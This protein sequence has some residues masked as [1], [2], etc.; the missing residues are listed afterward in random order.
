MVYVGPLHF[1]NRRDGNNTNRQKHSIAS[2]S[3]RGEMGRLPAGRVGHLGDHLVDFK[4]ERRHR[5]A[6]RGAAGT[7]TPGL[8]T[9]ARRGCEVMTPRSARRHPVGGTTILLQLA[10]L[11]L[12]L[13]AALRHDRLEVLAHGVDSPLEGGMPGAGAVTAGVA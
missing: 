1:E 12:A 5:P 2:L 7:T 6:A 9:L 3:R 11:G 13:C 4:R 8:T 10:T